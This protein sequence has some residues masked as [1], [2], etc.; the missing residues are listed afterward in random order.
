LCSVFCVLCSV[1]CVLCSVFNYDGRAPRVKAFSKK[2]CV[3]YAA[4]HHRSGCHGKSIEENGGGVN[5]TAWHG[6]GAG[7]LK[8]PTLTFRGFEY[9]FVTSTRKVRDE[10]TISL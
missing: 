5:A 2:S 1:F 3:F 6:A 8:M 9:I 4:A 10:R 7:G